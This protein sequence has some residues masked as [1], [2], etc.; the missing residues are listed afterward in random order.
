VIL[1]VTPN[2]AVDRTLLVPGLRPGEVHRAAQTI[3]AAGG[4]GLNAA[5]AMR[6]LGGD[7][8]CAGFLGGHSGR[9]LAELAEHESLRCVWTWIE[10]ETRTCVIV[11]DP[12]DGEATV[13]NEPGP[14]VAADDWARL[15]ADVLRAS[16][17]ADCVCLSGSLPPGASPNMLADLLRALR[18]AGQHVWV[19]MSGAA[20][21]AALTVEEVGLKVNSAEVGAVLDRAVAGVEAA[22]EAACALRQRGAGPV[23]LTLGELGA[24]MATDSGAW[25]ARPPAVNVLSAV[26]SGDVFLAGLVTALAANASPA[27]AL[28]QAVAAGAANALSAGGG[29]FALDD[30]QALLAATQITAFKCEERNVRRSSGS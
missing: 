6:A 5:R 1:C 26:G 7:P 11:V 24:V 14:A 10:G 15:Q 25:W 20:L 12:E 4:K 23:V 21:R 2:P 13:I 30:F 28:R 19:D 27:E 22:C 3:V 18:A 29:R 9:L 17:R 16:A 8:V